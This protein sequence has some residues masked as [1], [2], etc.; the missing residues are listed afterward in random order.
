MAE[1]Q[2][3]ERVIR[4]TAEE[5]G[6]FPGWTK[7]LADALTELDATRAKKPNARVT[8]EVANGQAHRSSHTGK[9]KRT[10]YRP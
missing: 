6:H 1:M 4:A 2:S 3:I 5:F 7:L 9:P 8:K 10:A